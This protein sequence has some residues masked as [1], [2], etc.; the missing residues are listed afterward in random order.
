MPA[1]TP[2]RPY[3]RATVFLTVAS[4]VSLTVLLL[5]V[6]WPAVGTLPRAAWRLG[7]QQRLAA[8][9][10]SV[11]AGTPIGLSLELPFPAHV[12]VASWSTLQGTIALFPSERLAS[13]LENPLPSGQHW[14]PGTLEGKPMT[15]PVHAVVGPIHYLVVA[16][17]EPIASLDETWSRLRQMG[18]MAR[19]G[20]A[21][22]DR[23]MYVFPPDAGMKVVPSTDAPAAAELEAARTAFGSDGSAASDGPMRHLAGQQGVFVRPFVVQGR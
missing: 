14:L 7:D 13:E 17:R 20:A 12:Y 4:L 11:P 15:W 10:K 2:K 1:P 9:G 8:E 3:S 18:Q 21:F 19:P 22:H 16:S 5:G 6:G 23:E